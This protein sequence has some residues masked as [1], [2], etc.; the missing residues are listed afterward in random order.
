MASRLTY[1]TTRSLAI[2]WYE[3]HAYTRWL[4]AHAQTQGWLDAKHGIRLPNEPEFEKAAR[5]GLEMYTSP[6][7][8][9]FKA[10]TVG[11]EAKQSNPLPKRRYPWGD[12]IDGEHCN[13]RDTGI[14]STSTGGC[15]QQSRSPYGVADM[16]GNVRRVE[17]FLVCVWK[18]S[19]R[20]KRMERPRK[21]SRRKRPCSSGRRVQLWR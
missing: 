15:F 13:Y 16:A 4:T 3:A 19:N 6:Q 7:C 18:I 5:G 20:S 10:L 17:S 12:A 11:S 9:P 8:A 21:R 2:S 1:P 14:G